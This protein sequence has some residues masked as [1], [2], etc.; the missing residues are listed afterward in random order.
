MKRLGLCWWSSMSFLGDKTLTALW[1]RSIW[2]A[3]IYRTTVL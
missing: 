3:K 2:I 1:L